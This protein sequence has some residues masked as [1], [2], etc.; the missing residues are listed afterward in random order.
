MSVCRH[1]INCV[2][3]FGSARRGRFHASLPGYELGSSVNQRQDPS[4]RGK[5]KLATGTEVRHIVRR[6]S[7]LFGQ[8]LSWLAPTG[9]PYLFPSFSFQSRL[10]QPAD[11]FW[12]HLFVAYDGLG[13][14]ERP[15]AAKNMTGAHAGRGGEGLELIAAGLVTGGQKGRGRADGSCVRRMGGRN[16]GIRRLQLLASPPIRCDMEKALSWLD[17]MCRLKLSPCAG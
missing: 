12:R 3:A 16:A 7:R 9:T 2:S 15:S 4:C 10:S 17:A 14:T 5:T 1:S 13:G 11:H 8:D 6:M